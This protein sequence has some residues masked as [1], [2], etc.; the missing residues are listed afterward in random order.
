MNK[1]LSFIRFIQDFTFWTNF[2]LFT[3]LWLYHYFELPAASH[4]ISRARGGVIEK[5]PYSRDFVL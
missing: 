1:P 2:R 4:E 3:F 5:K